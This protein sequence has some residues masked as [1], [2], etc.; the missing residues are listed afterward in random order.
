MFETTTRRRL[1]CGTG[2]AGA[3]LLAGCTDDGDGETGGDSMDDGMDGDSMGDEN[4]SMGDEND[5]M[6]ENDS[7][8]GTETDDMD[9]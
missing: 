9:G 5:S 7:M 8:D 2:A 4:D 3:A 6:G 1:L